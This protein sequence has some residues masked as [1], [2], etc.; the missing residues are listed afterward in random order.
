MAAWWLIFPAAALLP[1]LLWAEKGRRPQLVLVFKAPLSIL[2]V[3]AAL[4]SAW[5]RP[6]YSHLVLAALLLGLSGDMCLAFS[7][8]AAFMAGLGVFLAGHLAYVWAF[9]RL[10]AWAGW[11]GWPLAP[12]AVAAVAVFW[13][14]RPHAGRFLGPVAVYIVAI[15]AMLAGAW[16]VFAH[17]AAGPAGA[18]AVLLGAICFYLSD[19]FVARDRFIKDQYLN[20]LLGLPMYYGGQFLL[21]LSV[22][23]V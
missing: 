5:P 6:D 11:T 22:G 13:W 20:R 14:L 1:G 18:R 3:L 21:A 19:I 4:L 8:R 9:G 23:W 10:S 16:A 15:S 17:S 7:G 12:I 2:F